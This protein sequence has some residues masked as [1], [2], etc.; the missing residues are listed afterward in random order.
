MAMSDKK[1]AVALD[2]PLFLEKCQTFPAPVVKK[3]L[4]R[5]LVN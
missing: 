5:T 4:C 3:R 1:G 2:L